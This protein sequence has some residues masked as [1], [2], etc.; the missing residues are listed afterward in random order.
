RPGHDHMTHLHA[1][2]PIR[3]GVACLAALKSAATH[4]VG[5]GEATSHSQAMADALVGRVTGRQ[6]LTEPAPV[7]LR[8]VMTAESLL[9]DTDEPATLTDGVDHAT[10]I[11]AI[12]APVAR[13]WVTDAISTATAAGQQVPVKRLF[14]APGTRDLVAIESTARCFPAGLAELIATR[15]GWC[16][17]PY[18]NAPIRHLDHITPHAC[19]G[20]TSLTNGQGLCV[21]CNHAKEAPGWHHHPPP[22]ETPGAPIRITTPTGHHHTARDPAP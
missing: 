12:P 15:D 14:T 1:V 22:P 7:S 21:Q 5:T 8:L 2:L 19:G 17:T 20:P 6:P 11:D 4:A 13:Q 3:E 16:R 10:W 18:C 9:G